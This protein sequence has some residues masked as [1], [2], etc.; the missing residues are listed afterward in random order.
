MNLLQYNT[1]LKESGK[2]YIFEDWKC[3]SSQIGNIMTNLESITQK[4]L[5]EIPLLEAE[6]KTG[7]NAN[8]NKVKWTDNK[9]EKLKELIAKRDAPDELPAGA[10]TWLDAEFRRVFWG[11]ERMLFNK[12]LEK[13]N[14]MEEDALQLVS[15]IDKVFYAKNKEKFQN[16]Y[17]IGTPDHVSDLII[18]TKC[19]WDFDTYDAAKLTSIYEWQIKSYCW[20]AG[21]DKGVLA[22]CLVNSTENQVIN[23]IKSLWYQMGCPDQEGEKWL[24]AAMLCERNMIF[25]KKAFKREHP[26][27]DFENFDD[28]TIPAIFRVKKFEVALEEGDKK[29]MISRVLLA[30][31]YLLQKEIE[32][33]KKLKG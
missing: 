7:V 1:K 6:K 26:N 3:R 28:I 22:Y 12:Y 2:K 18:D 31:K 16:N 8:G 15:D 21:L 33:V 17:T 27:Y 23:A 19:S 14:I 30:R 10:I 9:A 13:G 32:T 4:Q 20:M 24:E 25:D 11:R 29:A 5:E